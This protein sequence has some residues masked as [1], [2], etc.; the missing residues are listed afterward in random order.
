MKNLPKQKNSSIRELGFEPVNITAPDGRELLIFRPVPFMHV[1][2]VDDGSDFVFRLNPP[3][4][5]DAFCAANLLGGARERKELIAEIRH[6]LQVGE[7]NYGVGGP[8][9]SET[10]PDSEALIHRIYDD[11]AKE[12]PHSTLEKPVE[13]WHRRPIGE[14]AV[15]GE[16][17]WQT[18]MNPYPRKREPPKREPFLTKS[19]RAAKQAADAAEV[20]K[21]STRRTSL[22]GRN[23]PGNRAPPSRARTA[24][25]AKKAG[26]P[27]PRASTARRA[28]ANAR[29]TMAPPAGDSAPASRA[30]SL[31]SASP[32]ASLAAPSGRP[33]SG[34]R[35]CPTSW[36][37]AASTSARS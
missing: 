22:F 37:S 3:I 5:S 7:A 36:S 20:D 35:R 1:P 4:S 30:A 17:A 31:A 32:Q 25:G 18:R 13:T 21:T 24:P 29:R 23:G 12:F 33:S 14:M 16:L 11:I 6:R 15:S 2:E 28:G 8:D 34:W 27:A 19:E 10:T 26:G 9:G